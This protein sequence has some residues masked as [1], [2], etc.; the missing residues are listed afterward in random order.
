[1]KSPGLSYCG[2]SLLFQET[3]LL[4]SDYEK[5]KKNP[6]VGLNVTVWKQGLILRYLKVYSQ[7][8]TQASSLRFQAGAGI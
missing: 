1:M 4:F 8:L 5:K 7:T 2:F 3:M 6:A